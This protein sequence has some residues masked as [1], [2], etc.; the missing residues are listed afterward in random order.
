MEAQHITTKDVVTQMGNF[1]M[2]LDS[3]INISF[4]A[5]I[6]EKIEIDSI[7]RLD[8]VRHL[9]IDKYNRDT[10]MRRI[11]PIEVLDSVTKMELWRM[12]GEYTD[13]RDRRLEASKIIYLIECMCQNQLDA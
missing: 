10:A 5:L 11:H 4:D 2:A 9:Y 3:V 13:D 1:G 6:R 7:L 8:S 12:A